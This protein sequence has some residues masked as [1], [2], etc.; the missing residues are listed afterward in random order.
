MKIKEFFDPATFT[1]TYLVF[2]PSSKDCVIIDPVLDYEP[3]GSTLSTTSADQVI[4]FVKNQKLN[5]HFILET[6]A[7]ADHITAA[8][9]I[10]KEFPSAKTALHENIKVVQKVFKDIFHFEDSF[11]T[12]GKVF[13]RLLKDDETLR[14][15]TL[16]IQVLHTPGHTPACVSYYIN[17]EAVFT[18]D[19]LF[20]P[21]FGTGRCDFPRGSA[22][23]LYE[24]IQRKLYVLPDETR[25]FVGHDY[26]PNQ[27]ELKFQS[28][29]AEEKKNNIQLK[30][31]T[32][33][34]DFVKF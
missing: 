26:Q 28:T 21:D 14:A 1:L 34:E 13:D 20:M 31:D 4:E 3:Q 10:K 11:D 8:P 24:S 19:A 9:H 6:H 17:E 18:G 16:R 33:K 12:D 7:H 5:I 15:G 25:V 30:A 32:K 2:D 22:D 27:R 29:I 23:D